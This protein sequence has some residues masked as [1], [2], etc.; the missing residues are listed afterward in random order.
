MFTA[1][2][3]GSVKSESDSKDNDIHWMPSFACI[4]IFIINS[5]SYDE[6]SV[7]ARR[8]HRDFLQC[9]ASSFN[10][11]RKY[12]QTPIRS[13]IILQFH[14]RFLLILLY[15]YINVGKWKEFLNSPTEQDLSPTSAWLGFL[16]VR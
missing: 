3:L 15:V 10:L 13:H 14:L 5:S 2:R 7:T 12:F 6:I 11:D 1:I 9:I 4:F 16:H 8:E